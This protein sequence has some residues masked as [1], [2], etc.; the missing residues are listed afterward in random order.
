MWGELRERELDQRWGALTQR[1][2]PAVSRGKKSPEGREAV[3]RRAAELREVDPLAA[4][5]RRPRLDG[6]WH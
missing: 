4:A 5:E 2:A 6:G 3:Q 1:G